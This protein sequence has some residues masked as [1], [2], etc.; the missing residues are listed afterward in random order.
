MNKKIIAAVMGLGFL[1]FAAGLV[2][3]VSA[4]GVPE[5]QAYAQQIQNNRHPDNHKSKV[6]KVKKDPQ[7]KIKNKKAP[8]KQVSKY[9]TDNKGKPQE[10]NRVKKGEPRPNINPADKDKDNQDVHVQHLDR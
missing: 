8:K 4:A 7:K 6:K 1:T 10:I 3:E 9:R 5:P 2:Y